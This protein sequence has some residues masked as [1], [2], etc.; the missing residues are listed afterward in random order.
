MIMPYMYTFN[1]KAEMQSTKP[2]LTKA[3]IL[4]LPYAVLVIRD[5]DLELGRLV[6]QLKHHIFYTSFH[7]VNGA[8]DCLNKDW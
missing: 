4:I 8:M 3:D 6:I 7:E 5:V 2:A 1:S